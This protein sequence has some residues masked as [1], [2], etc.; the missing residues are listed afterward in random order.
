MNTIKEE[1]IVITFLTESL[2][3]ENYKNLYGLI[4]QLLGSGG[5]I[6]GMYW[7]TRGKANRR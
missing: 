2:K 4:F 6:L 5:P 7:Q 1:N 3:D